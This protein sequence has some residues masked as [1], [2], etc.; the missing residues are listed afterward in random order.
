MRVE[1]N[2]NDCR[3]VNG[4]EEKP[5]HLSELD[6][7]IENRNRPKLPYLGADHLQTIHTPKHDC[8]KKAD[9]PCLRNGL[10]P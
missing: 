8:S 1:K 4:L 3:H 6:L 10:Q 9:L 7:D 5:Y 2:G